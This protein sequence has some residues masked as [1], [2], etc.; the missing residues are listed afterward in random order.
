MNLFYK[1]SLLQ[2]IFWASCFVMIIASCSTIK[3]YQPNKPF[4]FENKII[5]TG[6]VN[7]DEKKR[8]TEQLNNYWDDSLKSR[9]VTQFGIFYKLKNPPVLDTINISR[10]KTFMNAYLNSQGY[11]YAI[12]KDSSPIKIDTIKDQLRATVIM[13]IDVGKNITIDSVS[14]SLTDSLHKS[15]KDSI[16]QNLAMVQ[17]KNTVLVK[18]KPYNKQII[19]DELDRLVSWYRQ[20]GYYKFSREHVFALVDTSNEKLFKLTLDPIELAKLIAEADKT[21]RENP[22]WDITIKQRKVRDTSH[23]NKFFIGNIY[24]YP[25]MKITDS[26]DSLM[27]QKWIREL[28]NKK[29]D[30]IIRDYKGK[31]ILKPLREHTFLRRDSMY[32]EDRYYK[33]VNTLSKIPSWKQID[34]R[35]VQR[36]VDTL[37]L[38]FFLIPQKKIQ[39]DYRLETSR[40]SGDFTAGSLLGISL[41]AILNDRNVWRRAIQSSTN[42]TGGV[43]LNFLNAQDNNATQNN[44]IQSVQFSLSHTYSI[45]SLLFP[46]KRLNKIFRGV[47]NKRTII[48][49]SSSYTERFE[50]FRLR[51]INAGFGYEWQTKRNWVVAW[52]PLNIELYSIDTLKGLKLIFQQNP[53]LKN[54]FNSGNVLGFGLGNISYTKNFTSKKKPDNSHLIRLGFEES[55]LATSAIKSLDNQIY[56]FIKLEADYRFKHKFPKSEFAYRFFTGVGIPLSGQSLPFFKQYFAGGPN[57]MRAWGLRQLGLGSS[58]LSDTL[59]ATDF[60]DRFGDMQF[61]TN[62]EHRFNIASFGSLKLGSALFADIGNVWNLR[63]DLINT[64]AEF[65]LKR[66]TK[67]IAIAVGTGLRMD[68]SFFLIRVDF[69]YKV[70]D[71]GRKSTKDG[72]MSIQNFKWTEQ[73][74]NPPNNTTVRN[75]AFQLGIGLPF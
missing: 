10:S 8:L 75:F 13:K 6:N 57:S 12:I 53:F 45:P 5:V 16:L 52:R 63:K 34:A 55:G 32:N 38:H 69:A 39:T 73:R 37:D 11:Y 42:L 70:K 25:E 46:V 21:R 44:F 23:L 33:T 50:T 49:A 20:N 14:Y 29:G 74:D 51:N 40:N 15:K 31:F 19:S 18:G 47:D 48:N 64:D 2:K 24:Y 28:A 3:N 7:K 67:D 56:T 71:P 36:N 1:T 61:E 35:I 17:F 4:V 43:E 65:N 26:P 22:T 60:R 9:K 58:I 72:W 59:G 62:I 27:T 30:L 41:S 68:F 66:F 54:S